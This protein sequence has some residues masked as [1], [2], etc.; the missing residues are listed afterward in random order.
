[1]NALSL[2]L[3]YASAIV[4]IA[5][6][7][8]TVLA[9]NPIRSAISLLATMVG[10]AGLY[11]TLSA[12][13]LAAVQLIVYVGAVVVLFVF[14]IMIMGPTGHDNRD[15]RTLRV[16]AVSVASFALAAVGALLL[17]ARAGTGGPHFFDKAHAE[18]GT[19]EGLGN[20]LFGRGMVAFEL[21]GVLLLVALVAVMAIAR[22]KSA[23]ENELVSETE[24]KESSS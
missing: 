7:L 20:E 21:T 5:G 12:Q 4:A 1:M 9:R 22:T 2:V 14:V 10:I 13:L 15:S 19:V 11:L 17:L 8:G 18:F 16:R 6:S 24:S 3:F 23:P